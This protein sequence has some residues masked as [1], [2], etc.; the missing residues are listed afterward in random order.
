MKALAVIA[1][2]LVL[3]AFGW[4]MA[5]PPKD[6]S[7]QSAPTDHQ[8]GPPPTTT[9]T[10]AT[11]VFQKAFWKRPAEQDHILHAERREWADADGLKKWQWFIEVEPSPELVNHL[12]TANAFSL[13][14]ARSGWR[15]PTAGTPGWF[16]RPSAEH[17]ILEDSSGTFILIHDAKTNRILA[18]DSGGGFHPGGAPRPANVPSPSVATGRLPLTSPPNPPK[19]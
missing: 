16:S 1:L 11:E 18:T 17:Q 8:Q 13:R 14:P 15:E 2:T 3:A 12:I 10:D 7:D 6:Q 5:S 4:W 19:Q 9:L